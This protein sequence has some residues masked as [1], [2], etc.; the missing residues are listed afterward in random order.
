MSTTL[1]SK[2]A[3]ERAPTESMRSRDLEG[4][5]V[6]DCHSHFLPSSLLAAFEK[7]ERAPRVFDTNEG[8]MIQYGDGMIRRVGTTMIDFDAKMQAMEASGIDRAVV[9]INVPGLD[10][11]AKSDGLSVARTTNDELGELAAAQT[12]RVV[13]LAAL[14][15]QSG[16]GAA[17]ELERAVGAG[18]CGGLLFSNIAGRSLDEPEFEA[19]FET[20]ARLDV[21]LMIHPT[22][23]LCIR[24]VDAYSLQSI[25]GYLVDTSAAVLRLVLNGLYERYPDIKIYLTHAGS[26]LPYIV[27]RIDHG[28]GRFSDE[29]PLSEKPSEYL[30]RIY[31]DTICNWAPSLQMA[32]D[33]FSPDHVM[34]GTDAPFWDPGVNFSTLA[35]LPLSDADRQKVTSGNAGR[36]FGFHD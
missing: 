25:L 15:C 26:L 36:L 24:T 9:T 30:R 28:A 20:A 23:P 5:L 19:I 22:Y 6:T 17:R 14:P 18:L 12:G 4:L 32:I 33:F 16:D 21:P 10:W 34:F 11:F 3:G 31:T 13:A 1:A 29:A 27:G 7:R 35:T 2:V 8:K